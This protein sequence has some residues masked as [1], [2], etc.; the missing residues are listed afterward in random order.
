MY[1]ISLMQPSFG[2]EKSE[3]V[4]M[5]KLNEKKKKAHRAYKKYRV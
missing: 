5:Q 4:S 2:L 3:G 1:S